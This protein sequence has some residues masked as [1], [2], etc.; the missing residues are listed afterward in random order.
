MPLI[1]QRDGERVPWLPGYRVKMLDGHCIDASERRLKML[2]DVQGG[3]VT[4]QVVKTSR[5]RCNLRLAY[6]VAMDT[7]PACPHEVWERTPPEAPAYSRALEARGETWASMVPA[8]QEQGRTVQAQRHH[9]SQLTFR[10]LFWNA[11][12]I[13]PESPEESGGR[14]IHGLCHT[15]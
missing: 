5:L 6:P 3:A 15:P 11:E 13:S 1:T 7:L 12:A 8:V 2:R 10:T 9:T 14:A 4:V